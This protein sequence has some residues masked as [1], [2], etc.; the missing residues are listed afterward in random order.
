MTSISGNHLLL[1][2]LKNWGITC[3]AG[4][5][6][7]A[8]LHL[9]QYLEPFVPGINCQKKSSHF[10]SVMEYVAG[11]I[12]IG[13]YLASGKI[14]GCITT[15]GAASKLASCGMSDC[16]FQNIP[17]IYLV[18]LNVSSTQHLAPIQDMSADGM[19]FIPQLKAEFGTGCIVVKNVLH[20]EKILRKAQKK[21]M[22]SKPVILLLYPDILSQET[23]QFS[24]PPLTHKSYIKKDIDFFLKNFPILSKER[25]ILIYVCS[26]AAREEK[27]QQ[28][29][30]QLSCLLHAPTIW[31]VNGANA[32]APEN[33]YGY[34]YI[35][36]GGNDTALELWQSMNQKDVLITLGFDPGE[37]AL[38]LQNIPA[39]DVW[40]FTNFSEAYGYLNGK[41]KHRVQ[42]R[43]HQVRGN[44]STVLSAIL[45]KLK[46]NYFNHRPTRLKT[47][48]TRTLTYQVKSNCINLVDF[49]QNLQSLWQPPS[50][51]FDDVCISYK[52][53][54]YVTQKPHPFI[55][56][57]TLDQGSAMG[58]ALGLGIGARLSDPNLNIFIFTGDGCWRLFGAAIA[59]AAKLDL[60]LFLMNNGTY[61]IVDKGL[62]I[63]LPDVERKYYHCS[64]AKIDFIEA[65]KAYG[66]LS[67]KLNPD[68]SNLKEIMNF[69]YAPHKQ[70][71]LIDVPVD[72]DQTLGIN[73]R[74]Q[75]LK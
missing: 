27:I 55:K 66:W 31:S 60:R 44:I 22:Q 68:L 57:H 38:N 9:L 46:T 70:S 51:G 13:Y 36:F 61:A 73:V 48:N 39:G 45:P 34:G 3:F 63:I 8:V 54:Q 1:E 7:G 64:L 49:Y 28:Y 29:T 50:I 17:A 25:R 12:P 23:P 14:A 56:F 53:R 40:H 20:L 32:I 5:N 71:I 30:T 33:P 62:E 69:C 19:N 42:G 43:Y 37:Y 18:G 15:S 26:E 41:V 47:F 65:A 74:L 6:G 24:L 16:K 52:D 59:E 67:L 21:L 75:N 10:F 4:V 72:P 2:I 58:A 35:S 11:F